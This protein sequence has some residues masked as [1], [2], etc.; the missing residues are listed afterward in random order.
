LVTEALVNGT[1]L[2][3]DVFLLLLPKSVVVKLCTDQRKKRK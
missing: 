2:L 3:T 1:N